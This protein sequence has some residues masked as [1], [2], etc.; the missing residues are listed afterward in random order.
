[1]LLEVVHMGL[2]VVV[3]YCCTRWCMTG[4]VR[5]LSDRPPIASKV[6]AEQ[7]S[8]PQ[9]TQTQHSMHMS[10]NDYALNVHF[11]EDD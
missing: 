10:T 8:L 6:R 5:G 1:M 7:A 2:W 11:I 9:T 3:D 4:E